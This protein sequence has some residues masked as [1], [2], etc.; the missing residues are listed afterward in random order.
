MKKLFWI[1]LI[2]S[3]AM[4][5]IVYAID[6]S[7]FDADDDGD[8]D[9]EDLAGF[10]QHYGALRWYKDLDGDGHSDGITEYSFLKP[11]GFSSES[12]LETTT[13][14]CDDS[15]SNIYTGAEE[16]CDGLDNDCD[17]EID[18]EC[19]TGLTLVINEIDYDQ[20]GIDSMEFIEIYNFGSSTI[21]LSNLSVILVNGA[22]FSIYNTI[23]LSVAG[24]LTPGEYL[25][26]KSPN[27]QISSSALTI[28]FPSSE[29]NIQNGP[30]AIQLIKDFGGPGE[31]TVDSVTY[32]G[33]LGFPYTE[34]SPVIPGD[35]GEGS[36]GR[37]GGNDTGK[38]MAAGP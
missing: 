4:P 11:G 3:L 12:E 34:T 20:E 8:I 2:M 14:D 18:E 35:L 23:N 17:I 9:A 29:N 33:D 24:N 6:V 25:V 26:I 16:I 30:D 13:G 1:T 19:T 5:L 27:L 36:I 21:N 37:I 28:N 15:D 7:G 38:A 32:E 31:I 22:D 10:A